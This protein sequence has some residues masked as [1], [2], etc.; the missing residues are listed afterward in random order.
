MSAYSDDMVVKIP[1]DARAPSRRRANESA[2]L[3]RQ[4]RKGGLFG[5]MMRVRNRLS[6]ARRAVQHPG[7]FASAL[8]RGG[9]A[10]MGRAA[11]S[12]AS[13]VFANPIGLLVGAVVVGVVAAGRIMSGRSFE[14][15]GA[16]LKQ[17]LLG[18]ASAKALAAGDVRQGL[19]AD[20]HVA[21]V[22]GREGQVNSQIGRVFNDL[23]KL[24]EADHLGREMMERDPHFQSNNT[25]D[26]LVMRARDM[27]VQSWE[28][29]GGPSSAYQLT[30]RWSEQRKAEKR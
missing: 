17:M 18:D 3:D 15:M 28:N 2:L 12:R 5:K 24:R 25:A 6:L 10:S 20:D 13:R 26:I 8:V 11:A 9:A 19:M 14:N 22:V 30:N 7:R 29:C 21:A 1:L 23:K 27:L 4:R 16:E